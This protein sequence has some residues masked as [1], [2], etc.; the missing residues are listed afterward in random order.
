DPDAGRAGLPQDVGALIDEMT[1][2]R[3]SVTLVNVN[4][5]EP[6]RVVIQAGGYAE[7]RF[8]GVKQGGAAQPLD[9]T[10]VTVKLAPGAGS[11][12]TLTMKRHV[13][14]PTMAFPWH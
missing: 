4:Q 12:L 7:H 13:N 10:H 3:V 9:G 11:R 1:A 8:T 2:D 14:A 5:L 6:R